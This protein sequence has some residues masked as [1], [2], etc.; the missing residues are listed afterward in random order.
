MMSPVVPRWI[1][2]R[3]LL[4]SAALSV[5]LVLAYYLLPLRPGT[6]AALSWL[7]G[8]LA[9]VLAVLAY[10]VR[11][12]IAAKYPRLRAINA[13]AIGAPLIIVIFAA[14]YFLLAASDPAS[15][16]QPLDRTAALYFTVTVLATVGFG[17]ITP[18]TT[19]ARVAVMVQMAVDIAILGFAAKVLLG[20]VDRGLRKR[21]V[22]EHTDEEGGRPG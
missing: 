19:V 17:D 8:G 3:S 12:I 1:L 5:S 22:D 4:R 15:F 10:Q 18:V 2:V 14:T 9:V 16:S 7:V 13:L 11:A 20:A 6:G 21:T